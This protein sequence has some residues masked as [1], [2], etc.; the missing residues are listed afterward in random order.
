[1][2]LCAVIFALISVWLVNT[3][4]SA[5]IAKST[6]DTSPFVDD[7]NPAYNLICP[8]FT[9]L[10]FGDST[11]LEFCN[12]YRTSCDD[13]PDLSFAVFDPEPQ[14]CDCPNS[15]GCL[16]MSG[17]S[18]LYDG[19]KPLPSKMPS[20]GSLPGLNKSIVICKSVPGY[21][22]KDDEPIYVRIVEMVYV[23]KEASEKT[24]SFTIG[25]EMKS[26]LNG[27]E[28]LVEFKNVKPTPLPYVF[29]M[30][31][32][33][34]TILVI[35]ALGVSNGKGQQPKVAKSAAAKSDS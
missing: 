2:K 18:A 4:T 6:G 32:P 22:I 17:Y 25:M 9:I 34:Q 7:S 21:F 12:A 28:G 3:A 33:S 30:N 11:F 31:R 26:P 35:R 14:P 15:S 8:L 5:E 16:N 1:M 20:E 23:N 29:T 10:D 13:I 19:M 27:I 24:R